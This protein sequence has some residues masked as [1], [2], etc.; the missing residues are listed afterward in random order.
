M[1][2]GCQ[3]SGLGMFWEAALLRIQA[4]GPKAPAALAWSVDEIDP[5]WSSLLRKRLV[6]NYLEQSAS[7]F[8]TSRS[9]DWEGCL[10]CI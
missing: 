2:T 9:R 8:S 4:C 5:S 1:L 3:E 6:R 10:P 7:F